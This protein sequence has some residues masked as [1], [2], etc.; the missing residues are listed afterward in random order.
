MTS[1]P[2][3]DSVRAVRQPPRRWRQDDRRSLARGG[4]RHGDNAPVTNF[5]GPKPTILIADVNED[6]R[7]MLAEYFAFLGCKTV[8]AADGHEACEKAPHCDVALL[9]LGLPGIGGLAVA[10]RMRAS[11]ETAQKAVIVHTSWVTADARASVVA[12]GILTFIPKPIDLTL[13]AAQVLHAYQRSASLQ[14]VT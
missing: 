13:L 4:R 14:S 2:F 9:E 8:E 12:A 5:A 6:G 11:A 1:S 3:P 7:A 10:Q